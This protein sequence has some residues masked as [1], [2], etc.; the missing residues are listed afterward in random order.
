MKVKIKL[1][2]NSSKL[3]TYA[4][5]G[6][7]CFD[8]YAVQDA[9]IRPGETRILPTGLAFE[10]PEGHVMLLF[11][12]SS[13]SKRGYL[14]NVGVVDSDYRGEVFV[15]ITNSSPGHYVID[16]GERLGQALIIP[17]PHIEFEETDELSPTKRGD[18]G[19]GST[20][21]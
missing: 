12:R 19:F 5:D 2:R 8:F 18:G 15:S 10:I 17:R 6:S 9:I 16:A 14:S 20:G 11:L 21:L 13:L 7:A 3:P 1:M 4:T